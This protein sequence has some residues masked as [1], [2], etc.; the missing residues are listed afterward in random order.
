MQRLYQKI[1]LVF[2]ASLIAVVVISGL[3]WRVGQANLPHGEVL[4]L[5]GELAMAALPPL[6]ASRQVQQQAVERLSRRLRIDIALFDQN[7]API[8]AIGRPLPQPPLFGESGVWLRGRGGPAWSFRLPDGRWLVARTP[9][10]SAG[11]LL[12]LVFFLA[13]MAIAIAIFAYPVVRG[14]T[15]RIERLQTGVETLG[16]GNLATRVAVE[17]RDEVAHLAASFNRAA[18]RIEELVGAHRLLLANA[19]HE[20]RTPLSRIRLGLELF[21]TKPDPKI[22]A[23]IARD[24]A[25]LDDLIEEILLAS[26]LDVAPA[27]VATEEIDL[28]ALVAEECAH[29]DGCTLDGE[30]IVLRGDSRLLRRLV[31]NLLDNA[32]RHGKPPIRVDLRR[33]G[34]QASLS[35][36]DAGEGIPPS[37]R[38][39]VFLPFYRL[40]GNR[41]GAGLGLA[42]ARQIA[43]LH[44]GDAVVMARP[45]AQSC[46]VIMLPV[47]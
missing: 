37:K 20:L 38:E 13:A 5:A 12:G 41:K 25:E 30:L 44:G 34:P 7:R 24:I 2:L 23:D 45:D 10:R 29:Y 27:P 35:V 21:E 19:S 11:P 9:L 3:S 22:K 28:L 32:Q 31:R 16:A 14:L 36:I 47:H 39:D 40:S 15:R 18:S 1:Y 46:I 6:D 4:E 8:A 17:G 42:L 26:R 43:R 33:V